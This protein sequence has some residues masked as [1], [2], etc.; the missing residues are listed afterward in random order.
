MKKTLLA[1]IPAMMLLSSFALW[2]SEDTQIEDA[3][4]KQESDQVLQNVKTLNEDFKFSKFNTCTD[5]EKTIEDF[6][7]LFPNRYRWPMLYEANMWWAVDDMITTDI[8]VPTANVKEDTKS[9]S[10]STDYSTTNVQ[11][12]WVDEP[13]ILKTDGKYL[14]YYNNKQKKIYVINSPLD[15]KLSEIDLSKAQILKTIKIPETFY[16]VQLFLSDDKL[17][18]VWTR[19]LNLTNYT[20]ILDKS[21]RTTVIIY[22]TKD[23]TKLDLLKLYDINWSY[24][25]AR[26]VNNELYVISQSY[27]NFYYA[28]PLYRSDVQSWDLQPDIKSSDLLPKEID[29]SK[30]S[31]TWTVKERFDITASNVSCDD[32][33]YLLP[34]KETVEK[35]NISPSLAI[36]S[37]INLADLTKKVETKVLFGDVSQ[38]HMS[39]DN[40]YLVNNFYIWYNFNCPMNARCIMPAFRSWENSLIHKFNLKDSL[41]YQDSTI[42]PWVPLTQYSMEEDAEWYFKILTKTWWPDLDTHLFILSPDLSLKWKLNNIQPKEE[43]KSSRY[44][45]DKLYLVTFERTD[46]L[47]VID[48]SDEAN[49]KKVWELKIPWY[50]TY[51]HPY[52]DQKDW[53]QYLIGLGYDTATNQWGGTQNAWIKIDL[54][55]IDYNKKDSNNNISIEQKFTTTL[56]SWGSWS[57]ALENPRM[58]VWDKNKK[59]LLMPMI[60]Q[61]SVAEKSCYIDYLLKQTCSDVYRNIPTFAWIKWF[62]IDADNGIKE[63]LSKDYID[64]L[65]SNDKENPYMYFSEWSFREL[66]FRVGYLG[67][68]IY[69]LN[70]LI[71]D[72]FI[73]SDTSKSQILYFEESLQK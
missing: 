13:E 15:T 32:M 6:V 8:A 51:L 25:D 55:K 18:I 47:F 61:K 53:V 16:G 67:D 31:D 70:N 60:L 14:Y 4:N 56:W 28:Y 44:I 29:V 62:T 71:W 9:A 2:A 65:K 42:I 48:M 45:W 59:L 17:A 64:L 73:W 37:K 11:V 39:N 68:A 22:D 41:S 5:M 43:F 58:F 54:Y 57:E 66:N 35:Y 10:S 40:L 1:F 3:I 72:F 24:Y 38:I 20:S 30:K 63:T 19:Y 23:V 49:P 21:T 46:P 33:M 34:T 27:L 12:Q 52:A 7:K 26:F 69:S 50:S 36:V